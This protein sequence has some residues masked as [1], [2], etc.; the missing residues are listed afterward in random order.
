MSI[1]SY[2]IMALLGIF[3]VFLSGCDHETKNATGSRL[4]DGIGTY[5]K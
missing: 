5:S 2:V 3:G 4:F 1:R